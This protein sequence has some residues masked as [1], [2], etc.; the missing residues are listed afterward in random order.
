M[1]V[2][3]ITETNWL[4]SIV[5]AQDSASVY[6]MSLARTGKIEIAIPEY[7]FHEADGSLNRKLV[8]RACRIDE[9][10]SL[11]GQIWQTE[12]YKELCES[13]KDL[14][15]ELK[16]LMLCDRSEIKMAL[17]EIK[18]M[19]RILPYTSDASARAEMRF[20]SANPPFKEGDC[21]IYE[22]IL[23]FVEQTGEKYDLIMFYTE[24][25][26]DFDHPAIRDELLGRSVEM[27]FDSG[28]CVKRVMDF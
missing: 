14:L 1:S 16:N 17:D 8:K 5:L 10:L 21:R 18:S 22:S 13:C 9:A 2:L 27:L 26:E 6:L 24:D 25:R 15:K 28:M 7:S 19:V 4:E 11:L 12:H 3:L 23:M 20:E